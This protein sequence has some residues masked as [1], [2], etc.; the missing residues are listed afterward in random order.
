MMAGVGRAEGRAADDIINGA[1]E[2]EHAR[3]DVA[4]RRVDE[5]AISAHRL[6]EIRGPQSGSR[7]LLPLD[8]T[9]IKLGSFKI[10]DVQPYRVWAGGPDAH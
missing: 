1:T 7:M 2:G 9:G 10:K 8:E 5:G 6:A 4:V 3:L